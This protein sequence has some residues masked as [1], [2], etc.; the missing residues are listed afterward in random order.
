MTKIKSLEEA[1][2]IFEEATIV[3]GDC[4]D[5]SDYKT[6]NKANSRAVKAL[7]YLRDNKQL[8]ELKRFFTHT[9]IGPRKWAAAELLPLTEEDS[10]K[11]LTEISKGKGYNA[12]G[13]EYILKEW[14]KPD[15]ELRQRFIGRIK[16]EK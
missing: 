11:V 1:L 14:A 6:G 9:A 12:F 2:K 4:T 16:V 5:N 13:A 10:V 7:D 15:S 8:L 3:H